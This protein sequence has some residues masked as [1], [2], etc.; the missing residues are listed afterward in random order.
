MA[1]ILVTGG[2]GFLGSHLVELLLV[3]CE[4][5]VYVIDDLSNNPVPLNAL[6]EELPS[7]PRLTYTASRIESV[8]EGGDGQQ[9][10]EIYHL[11]SPVGSVGLLKYAGCIGD[12]ILRDALLVSQKALRWGARLVYVSSS[13][14]YGGGRNGYCSECMPSLLG[15]RYTPRSEYAAGKLVAEVALLN[16]GQTQGLDV[17]I[18]RPFNVAG[19]RQSGRGGFVLPRFIGQA[20]AKK[21]IT[22]FG[23]GTQKRAFGHVR[24]IVSGIRCAARRSLPGEVYNLGNADNLCTIVE[25]AQEVKCA[26]QS[27][28]EIVLVDPKTIYGSLYAE[29]PDKYPDTSKAQT[30]LDWRAQFTLGQIIKDTVRYMSRAPENILD[31]S[32][33]L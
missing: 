30:T 28:S 8:F 32:K 22:V 20:L 31:R 27:N 2:F 16:L 7:S 10:E 24:D 25:L 23:D 15:P 11:A 29:A 12:R 6:L 13:E 4:N 21:P 33:G 19:P 5:E 26:T 18:V 17:V 9:F 3:D 14:I 1:R